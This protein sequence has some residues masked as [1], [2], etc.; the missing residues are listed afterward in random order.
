[1][2]SKKWNLKIKNEADVAEIWIYGNIC[3]DTDGTFYREVCG[4]EGFVFPKE[5]REQ[6]DG[7]GD[8]PVNVYIASDGGDVNAGFAIANIIGRLKGKTTAFVDSWAAS[9]AS[10]ICLVC[11]E[12]VMPMN[13]FIMIHNPACICMGNAKDMRECADLLDTMRDSIITVYKQHDKADTDFVPLMD[14]ETWLSAEESSKIWDH[15]KLV[16]ATNKAVACFSGFASAPEQFKKHEHEEEAKPDY[17]DLIKQAA[18]VL[19]NDK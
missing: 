1:M 3:D 8:K 2:K 13:T 10:V 12:V 9:I 18:E 19:E 6:L 15:V 4:V 7:I 16:E 14:A 5:I 11:D 17:S